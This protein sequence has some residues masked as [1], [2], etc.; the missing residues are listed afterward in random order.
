MYDDE[1]RQLIGGPPRLTF[2]D[3]LHHPRFP[4]A[5][6]LYV[7][8]C[9]AVYGN[10][11]FLV[12]L[13]V[14]TGRFFVFNIIAVLEAAQDPGRRETWLTIAH[15]KEKMSTLGLGSGRHV[16]SLIGR[17][18]SVGFM[19][20]RPAERDRRVRILCGTDKLWAH[21]REW[22]AAH[23]APLA[24]LFPAHDYGPILRRDPQAHA[25]FLRTGMVF[26]PLSL[27]IM[28]ANRDIM[29]FFERAGG[30]MVITA[31]LQAAMAGRGETHAT[32]PYRDVGDR[33]GIS[34]THVRRLL[35]NG[36]RP[37][38]GAADAAWSCCRASRP[39]TIT[40]RRPGCI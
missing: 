24:H 11:P 22:L 21:H 18:C 28:F 10:D 23:F 37:V 4:E 20:Q 27:K 39:P 19:E 38:S 31:L 26:L 25:H 6:K 36:R 32:V 35:T 34:R 5:R 1:I 7:D 8:R 9:L 3:V 13:L 40:P 16:D 29:L 12:R 14:E 2:E 17:L 33:F 30:Y 15:L